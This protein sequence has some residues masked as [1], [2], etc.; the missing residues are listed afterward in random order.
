MIKS[1]SK[2]VD[3]IILDIQKTGSKIDYS[4]R[5]K[6]NASEIISKD[7]GLIG[8]IDDISNDI[9]SISTDFLEKRNESDILYTSALSTGVYLGTKGNSG[10]ISLDIF[11]GT[12]TRNSSEKVDENTVYDLASVTKLYTLILLYKLENLGYINLNDKIKDVNPRYS[13]LN[14]F[15]FNDLIRLCGEV[16]T[17]SRVDTAKSANEAKKILEGSYLKSE[18]RT[19]N[20]YTDMGAL[21]MADTVSS[22]MSQKLGRKVTYGEVMKM[23]MF[24]PL[25]LNNTMFN[26]TTN[27]S[28]NG[29]GISIPHDPKAR[30]L[31]GEAGSAGLYT[32]SQDLNLLASTIFDS[33]YTDGYLDK[34]YISHLGEITFPTSTSSHK[35]NLGIYVKHPN[36]LDNTFT[37]NELS[38]GSFSHEGWT[39]A[40]ATFD[41]NNLIHYNVLVNAI[42]ESESKE[43]VKNDKV[44]GFLPEL[45]KYQTRLTEYSL[46]MKIIKEY[47]NFNT[48]ETESIKLSKRIN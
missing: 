38:D 8:S 4:D 40:L 26:P 21:I 45:K 25:N 10:D 23:F 36:G 2:T 13:G 9:A 27:V 7:K 17:P 35:G 28:G 5:L 3:D 12:K 37:P 41:Y 22:I 32:T 31:G 47:Y 18:D 1:N 43:F 24:D 16:C 33:Y 11:G 46:L 39:G 14:D 19:V 29:Y 48:S 6:R 44:I 15:T 42:Y 34:E 30:I 20:K